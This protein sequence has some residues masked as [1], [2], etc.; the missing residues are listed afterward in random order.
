M[1]EDN[2]ILG[3]SFSKDKEELRKSLDSLGDN[4]NFNEN[5]WI[6]NRKA[7]FDK[8]KNGDY[9]IVFSNCPLNYIEITKYFI[10]ILFSKERLSLNVVKQYYYRLLI[11][12]IFLEKNHNTIPLNSLTPKIFDDYI[13]YVQKKEIMESTKYQIIMALTKFLKK[14]KLFSEINREYIVPNPFNQIRADK[15]KEKYIDDFITNQ[16]DKIFTRKDI[17]AHIKTAY[18]IMRFIPSRIT[19][20]ACMNKDCIKPYGNSWVIFIP[21]IKQSGYAERA[22]IRS[23]YFKEEGGG[24]FLLNL[25]N[26]QRDAANGIINSLDLK[27]HSYLFAYRSSIFAGWNEDKS[28]KYKKT[29]SCHILDSKIITKE[30]NNICI[31]FNIVD[32]NNKIYKFT[33]H[34]L[35]HTGIT[36]RLMD[37]FTTEQVSFMTAQKSLGMIENSYD[38]MNIF[39]SPISHKALNNNGNKQ[40]V[41]CGSRII[42]MTPENEEKI[43]KNFKTL[44]LKRGICMDATNCKSGDF[45]CL[46]NCEHYIYDIADYQYFINLRNSIMGKM[47]VLKSLP[48]AYD[49]LEY[50]LKC[51]ENAIDKIEKAMRCENEKEYS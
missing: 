15:N 24:Q 29:N 36:D 26:K 44:K 6:C 30:F 16:L 33:S 37:G 12:F 10:I 19:E 18:W 48:Y 9:T 50:K 1:Y 22:E 47:P 38:H 32:Q 4:I 23:I 17:K 41:L 8:G 49:N 2:V 13:Y 40:P 25:I 39:P 11:F 45:E 27:L 31:R 3:L 28:I 5:R 20:V 43:L 21:N 42:N 34:Q 35:R 14:M 46:N 51:V 7:K